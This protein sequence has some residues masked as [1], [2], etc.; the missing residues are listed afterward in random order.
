MGSEHVM[1]R[2]NV[3]NQTTTVPPGQP[4]VGLGVLNT[5]GGSSATTSSGV[6]V[7]SSGSGS[8]SGTSSINNNSSHHHSH[9]QQKQQHNHKIIKVN[10]NSM[11]SDDTALLAASVKAEPMH[12]TASTSS[13]TNGHVVY[14][15]KRPRLD[16]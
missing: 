13:T 7:I 8:A 9:H 4:I 16:G 14:A 6:V 15:N 5:T 3:V 1:Y 11:G 10:S 12:D 2:L